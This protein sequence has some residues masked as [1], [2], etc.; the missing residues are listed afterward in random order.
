[1]NKMTKEGHRKELK[2]EKP[3]K[4]MKGKEKTGGK[5]K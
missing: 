4:S 1:M 5:R 2:G 3:T